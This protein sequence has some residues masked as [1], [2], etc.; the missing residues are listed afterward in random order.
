MLRASRANLWGAVERHAMMLA[1][2]ADPLPVG[3]RP[4]SRRANDRGLAAVRAHRLVE[5]VTA[6]EAGVGSDPS[7]I[8]AANNYG[9]ALALAGRR[10]DAQRVLTGVLLRD[11]TRAVAWTALAEARS[12][13]T[14][15]ALAALKL[16]L[17]FAASRERTLARFREMAQ[18]HADPRIRTLVST[19]LAQRDEVPTVPEGL[20]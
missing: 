1:R 5:A 18:T 7:D 16:S 11:P 13:D 6:F 15:S 19:V 4:A 12:E 14:A 20:P 10:A 9:Y 3:D 8:E 17:H 2:T